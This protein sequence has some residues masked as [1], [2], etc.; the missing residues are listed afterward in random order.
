MAF[1]AEVEGKFHLRHNDKT[2][3]LTCRSGKSTLLASLF[4]MVDIRSGEISIDDIDIRNLHLSSLRSRINAIPQDPFF[5]PGSFCANLDP[6]GQSSEAEMKEALVRV[7]LWDKVEQ[8]GGLDAQ[9][10]A[11]EMSQGEKQLFSMARAILRRDCKI[12][13]LDEVSS[14]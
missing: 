1:A 12:V 7:R 13:V 11:S 2:S 5:L 9:L 8:S 3:Y 6:Y 14:R 10:K 4:R